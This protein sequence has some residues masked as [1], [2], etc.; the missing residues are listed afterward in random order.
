MINTSIGLLGV[1]KQT[2]KTTPAAEPTFRHGLTGGSLIKPERS[3]EQKGIACG[4][5]ANTSNSSYVK[6]V[7]VA[8]DCETMSY[9]DAFGLYST[10]TLGNCVTT[11]AAESGYYK[12]VITLGSTIPYL[13]FWGQIGDTTQQTVQKAVGCKMDT[14]NLEFDGNDPLKVGLTAAGLDADL[15][16]QFPGS[17]EPSCFDGYFIPTNGT[18][19]FSAD[20]QTPVDDITITKG[21]FELSNSLEGTRGAGK[22]SPSEISESKLKTS[23]KV[24][25]VPEDF[26]PIRRVLTGSNTGTKLAGKIVYGSAAW[27]FTHSQDEKCTLEVEFTNVPWTCETPQVSPDG[28]AAE[29][30]FSADDI[31]VASK[32]GSPIK[33]TLVN[34]VASYV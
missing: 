21:S 29:V 3:V 9:A 20:S 28:N 15:F 26:S 24:T 4:L 31:G 2:D 7:N 34:K 25:T 1:A 23:V 6:E 13:T 17:V 19:K 27:S 32:S 18:F 11:P 10:A 14:L 33:I 22:V 30:E 12:H 16:G 5:R 8:I